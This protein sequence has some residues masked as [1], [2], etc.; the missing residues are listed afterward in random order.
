MLLKNRVWDFLNGCKQARHS[1]V[2][3]ERPAL[4]IWP[5][6]RQFVLKDV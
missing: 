5:A 1:A 3:V 4:R 2:R 6:K